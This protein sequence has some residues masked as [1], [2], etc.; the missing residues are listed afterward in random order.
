[1]VSDRPRDP[2]EALLG[3]ALDALGDLQPRRAKVTRPVR[4]D[5][6]PCPDCEDGK[7]YE[8]VYGGP[9]D[10]PGAAYPM[11]LREIGKCETCRGEGK[12]FSCPRCKVG[13]VAED[14]QFCGECEG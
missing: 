14:E 6:T 12:L 11:E 3:E 7:V 1:M 10:D 4:S 2:L 13:W 5:E 8:E 9:R